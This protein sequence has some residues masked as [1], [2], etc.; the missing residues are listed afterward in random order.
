MNSPVILKCRDCDTKQD[1]YLEQIHKAESEKK[2]MSK[3]VVHI[4]RKGMLYS[5]TLDTSKDTLLA[6]GDDKKYYVHN[7]LNGERHFYFTRYA[8]FD[9]KEY[10][11]I[12]TSKKELILDEIAN[13][14]SVKPTADYT[15]FKPKEL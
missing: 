1:E 14:A 12:Q 5:M 2:C 3:R 6:T 9:E 7:T 10:E 15:K 4:E 8:T 13:I 11:E